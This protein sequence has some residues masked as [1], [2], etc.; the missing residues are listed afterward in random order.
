MAINQPQDLIPGSAEWTA[1]YLKGRGLSCLHFPK[2]RTYNAKFL[3]PYPS[4]LGFFHT[5]G[6]EP[7]ISFLDTGKLCNNC[8]DL[9]VPNGFN[10]WSVCPR[11]R[12]P[13]KIKDGDSKDTEQSHLEHSVVSS[14]TARWLDII[15][16]AVSYPQLFQAG[17]EGFS[18]ATIRFS[19]TASQVTA[20]PV[21]L[22]IPLVDKSQEAWKW[23]QSERKPFYIDQLHLTKGWT[24]FAEKSAEIDSAIAVRVGT[25]FSPALRKADTHTSR[26]KKAESSEKKL[27]GTD[28][29]SVNKKVQ[30]KRKALSATNKQPPETV[31]STNNSG[32]MN[33]QSS[34]KISL[35]ITPT[36]PVV[37]TPSPGRTANLS[38][39]TKSASFETHQVSRSSL[40]EKSTHQTHLEAEKIK[41]PVDKAT[42]E[43]KAPKSGKV[44]R[45]PSTPTLKK[46]RGTG[47]KLGLAGIQ[48]SD[49]V[50]HQALS[51][52]PSLH[53]LSVSADSAS[54]KPEIKSR[55]IPKTTPSDGKVRLIYS[56]NWS[57]HD[58]MP[59]D[60]PIK[61]WK[62]S[63]Y[64]R[65]AEATHVTHDS[66]GYMPL[67]DIIGKDNMIKRKAPLLGSN[68]P[69]A[70]SNTLLTKLRSPGQADRPRNIASSELIGS[71][72]RKQP[73]VSAPTAARK[74]DPTKHLPKIEVVK[75]Q[76]PKMEL[77]DD[78]PPKTEKPR[79]EL[80][81]TGPS[82]HEGLQKKPSKS[83]PLQNGTSKSRSTEIKSST[84]EIPGRKP[85]TQDIASDILGEI[86]SE[87]SKKMDQKTDKHPKPKTSHNTG[88][89]ILGAL[90]SGIA[91]K[92]DEMTET[93][94][95]SPQPKGKAG[96]TRS[97][98]KRSGKREPKRDNKDEKPKNSKHG[99]KKSN[100]KKSED[101]PED[102]PKDEKPTDEK[103]VD[104]REDA[105]IHDKTSGDHIPED[106]LDDHKLDDNKLDDNKLDDNK[107]DDNKLDD[108]KLDDNKLD[109]NKL[110][111]NKLDDNKP[112]D[113]K[114]DDNKPD[115][116]KPDDNKPD[117]SKSENSSSKDTDYKNASFEDSNLDTSKPEYI[118]RSGTVEN[119]KPRNIH[120]EN[121]VPE[122][123]L[124]ESIKPENIIP[125]NTKPENSGREN[126]SSDNIKSQSS[127][128]ENIDPKNSYTTSTNPGHAVL[129]TKVTEPLPKEGLP[130]E[131]PERQNQRP[132]QDLPTAEPPTGFNLVDDV[133]PGNRANEPE[134]EQPADLLPGQ[135]QP[136]S[137]GAMA[138][139]TRSTPDQKNV[140]KSPAANSDTGKP[141]FPLN[142][143]SS[144]K[145]PLPQ[146][147]VTSM[148][149]DTS[150]GADTQKS[151]SASLAA[152][153]TTGI[154]VGGVVGGLAVGLNKDFQ[155]PGLHIDISK[156]NIE[157]VGASYK[158][159]TSSGGITPAG[160]QGSQSFNS[161]SPSPARS[162]SSPSSDAG[163]P[164]ELQD[165]SDREH[166]YSERSYSGNDDENPSEHGHEVQE[167]SNDEAE[168]RKMEKR[169]GST[170]KK[171]RRY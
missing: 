5:L 121:M 100:D 110:D 4:R 139:S 144:V 23:L 47:D 136:D 36:Q 81:E 38:A 20:L 2:Y 151:S 29:P 19:N 87:I 123:I 140:V 83:K 158:G 169:R 70:P 50:S 135:S 94:G 1:T 166:A 35:L 113:N 84:S 112:D 79:G 133:K 40:P 73:I 28:E 21:T 120:P 154:A 102:K 16:S 41:R 69:A 67:E 11:S 147:P 152:G 78:K 118:A 129:D 44:S 49:H 109:D 43:A 142:N 101:K 134:P 115:D 39:V 122:N 63:D 55:S 98:G 48:R 45:A 7:G 71:I 126:T 143:S 53:I 46:H 3:C 127:P 145:S 22:S 34:Q 76:L 37:A 64:E 82:K 93:S 168:V 164:G 17:T 61:P 111:D 15:P 117:D 90:K 25:A 124:R 52:E 146:K 114:P 153:L 167:D 77:V 165:S 59:F 91:R 72:L 8:L 107:L 58:P 6:P 125:E 32:S 54:L 171:K 26:S 33:L 95:S 131:P 116:N 74:D 51:G 106:K 141:A 14:P 62:L 24:P 65:L 163:Q 13:P 128:Q 27:D 148:N 170:M 88:P 155:R 108:N 80:M 86:K 162:L 105:K 130:I 137:N 12:S 30:V 161:R 104:K 150:M 89:S 56:K 157:D 138:D 96:S 92:I 68:S 103:L 85:N 119:T 75:T 99:D 132:L 31:N 149:T 160:S 42:E 97:E 18:D 159:A 66:S 60:S 156:E 57:R 10:Y 9:V